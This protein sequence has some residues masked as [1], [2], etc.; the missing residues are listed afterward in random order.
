MQTVGGVEEPVVNMRVQADDFDSGMFVS[1]ARTDEE[2]DYVISALPQGRRY[3]VQTV[4]W[5]NPDP[6]FFNFVRTY[7]HDRLFGS[8]ADPVPASGGLGALEEHVDFHVALGGAI[9][10]YVTDDETG[11][12]LQGINIQAWDFVRGDYVNSDN[13]DQHGFYIIRGL[14]P[15]QYR[16]GTWLQG[17]NYVREYLGAHHRFEPGHAGRGD[18]GHRH[19]SDRRR[20]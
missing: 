11:L 4:P 14:P 8:D 19:H 16:V 20:D 2:G 10:G 9:S 1:D 15:G 12:P 13:T 17:Q 6:Q 7:W 5:D 18:A 3:R